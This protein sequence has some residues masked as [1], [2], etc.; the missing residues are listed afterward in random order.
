VVGG[1]PQSSGSNPLVCIQRAEYDSIDLGS[2]LGPLGGLS[3]FVKKGQRV[4]LKVNLLSASVPEQAIVTDP[5]LVRVVAEAVLKAGGTPVVGDSPGGP[6][7]RGTL[8]RVYRK[9]GL[10]DLCEELGIELNF[11]T[12]SERIA[13]SDGKRISSL[14]LCSFVRDVDVIISLPKIKSHSFQVLSLGVKNMFG[15]MAGLSKARCHA[16]FVRRGAF[17]DMLLDVVGVV[18][19]SL[20]VLDGVVGMMGEGPGASGTPVHVG[21]VMAAVDPVA[22]DVSVCRMLGVEPVRVP[23]L[24]Q[25]RLRGLWPEGI[26]YPLLSPD[27]VRFEGFVLPKAAEK[28]VGGRLASRRVP[29]VGSRCTGCG[30]CVRIC[31]KGAM[32][33]VGGRAVPD[34]EKCIRCYCCSEVCVEEAIVLEEIG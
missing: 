30:D 5:R 6:F 10:I 15:V 29:V 21:V 16:E 20:S 17:A 2:L 9:A 32:R 3:S 31:P 1:M 34:L 13:V 14:N 7:T 25:A 18:P 33:L 26:G 4:L 28:G 19:P 11:K 22:L 12:G 24:R 27:D 23:V 8:T